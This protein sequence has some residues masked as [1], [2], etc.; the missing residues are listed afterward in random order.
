MPWE[1]GYTRPYRSCVPKV[2]WAMTHRAVPNRD[3]VT[4][5]PFPVR[6]RAYRAVMTAPYS[7]MPVV[8]SSTLAGVSMGCRKPPGMSSEMSLIKPVAAQNA[9][10]SKAGL[11]RGRCPHSL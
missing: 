5:S 7:A 10:V 6:S 9:E 11:Y 4:R 3:A 8:Q 1:R 2:K